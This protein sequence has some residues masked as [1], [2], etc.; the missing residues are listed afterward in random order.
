MEFFLTRPAAELAVELFT[1][2]SAEAASLPI[3]TGITKF[4]PFRI[5]PS[6]T[7]DL[8]EFVIN[9]F[10]CESDEIFWPSKEIT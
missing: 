7:S 5:I 3:R 9:F 8:L 4:L 2:L 1:E 10:N 6:T